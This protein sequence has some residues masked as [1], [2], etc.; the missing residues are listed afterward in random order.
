VIVVP[1]DERVDHFAIGV[2]G[3][4]TEHAILVRAGLGELEVGTRPAGRGLLPGGSDVVHGEGDVVDP[5]AMTVD[6]LGD[7]AIR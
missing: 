1:V 4:P 7:L 5:V 6:V 2:D 3:T